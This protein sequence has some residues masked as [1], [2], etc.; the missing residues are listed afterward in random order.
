M[1]VKGQRV[2]GLMMAIA[3]AGLA[4]VV[5]PEMEHRAHASSQWPRIEGSVLESKV[6]AREHRDGQMD[7]AARILYRYQVDGTTYTATRVRFGDEDTFGTIEAEA[8]SVVDR[9]PANT[10]VRVAYDPSDP[11]QAVLEPGAYR[12]SRVLRWSG[13]VLILLGALL[14]LRRGAPRRVT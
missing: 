11:G 14:V 10:S 4:L 6:E 9:Y 7:F 3:G 5:G 8:Q 2:F 13:F 12:S 1:N